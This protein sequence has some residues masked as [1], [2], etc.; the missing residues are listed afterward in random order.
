MQI[1]RIGHLT[2]ISGTPE[3]IEMEETIVEPNS[4]VTGEYI[5]DL[6]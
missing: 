2:E 1:K 6:K 3:T 4:N 5:V